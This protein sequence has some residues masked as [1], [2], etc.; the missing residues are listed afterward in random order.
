M[1]YEQ[2]KVDMQMEKQQQFY[3]NLIYIQ[4]D[5]TF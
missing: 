1:D 3:K 5:S 2:I 4:H